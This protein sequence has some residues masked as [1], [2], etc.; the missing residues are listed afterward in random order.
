MEEAVQRSKNKDL[1]ECF[2]PN[3]TSQHKARSNALIESQ[4]LIAEDE[5]KVVEYCLVNLNRAEKLIQSSRLNLELD[6]GIGRL[7]S[8]LLW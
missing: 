5:I 6:S 4:T 2:Q 7:L 8:Y 1:S 3:I